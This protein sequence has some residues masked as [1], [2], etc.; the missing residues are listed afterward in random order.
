MIEC[1]IKNK[2]VGY[3]KDGKWVP[4]NQDGT[5]IPPQMYVLDR[6]KIKKICRGIKNISPS[7][8]KSWREDLS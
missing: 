1:V 3:I 4:L 7:S 6:E 2:K 8:W 5:N